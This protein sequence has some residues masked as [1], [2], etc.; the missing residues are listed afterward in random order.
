MQ[1]ILEKI[2]VDRKKANNNSYY[3]III[4][5]TMFNIT[6]GTIE[7]ILRVQN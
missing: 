1:K 3:N 4:L 5:Y 6:I 7:Y 2:V